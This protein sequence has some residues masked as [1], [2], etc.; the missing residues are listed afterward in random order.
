MKKRNENEFWY[1]YDNVY[2][3][4]KSCVY[5]ISVREVGYCGQCLCMKQILIFSNCVWCWWNEIWEVTVK[6]GREKMR[7]EPVNCLRWKKCLWK[8][9]VS[10]WRESSLCS[11]W[12]CISNDRNE[13]EMW[14]NE[15]NEINNR[16]NEI[17]EIWYINLIMK[18]EKPSNV[19]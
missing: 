6:K 14:S 5:D 15:N 12:H 4:L 17:Y 19:K 3:K 11:G 1:C 8:K 16:R 13:S 18:K 7:S 9:C 10:I 2:V